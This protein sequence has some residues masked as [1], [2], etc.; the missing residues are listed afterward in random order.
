[1]HN[2][3][4]PCSTESVTGAKHNVM[5]DARQVLLSLPT[6]QRLRSEHEPGESE[7]S[8]TQSK[9]LES[10]EST[11]RVDPNVSPRVP[12]DPKPECDG[13]GPELAPV[14]AWRRFLTEWGSSTV[15]FSK[16][17]RGLT[18]ARLRAMRGLDQ[19]EGIPA[20]FLCAFRGLKKCAERSAGLLPEDLRP[21][22]STLVIWLLTVGPLVAFAAVFVAWLL[23]ATATGRLEM[24]ESNLQAV[25]LDSNIML[26][27][28]ALS[29]Q[30]LMQGVPPLDLEATVHRVNATNKRITKRDSNLTQDL[31]G[32][33]RKAKQAMQT[34]DF[35]KALVLQQQILFND[36]HGSSLQTNQTLRA[37]LLIDQGYALT[38]LGQPKEGANFLSAGLQQIQGRLPSFALNALG[39]AYMQQGNL[40][41][42]WDAFSSAAYADP[43]QDIVW[44]NMGVTALLQ[45]RHVHADMAFEQAV[46]LR[47]DAPSIM[48]N[49]LIL[50]GIVE[51]KKPSTTPVM[52][53]FYQDFQ[54]EIS[55]RNL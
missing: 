47:P 21:L 52:E 45:G 35:E 28:P 36:T 42:A 7:A 44:S 24:P 8:F 11:P 10:Q 39:F 41:H 9:G 12:G 29:Q 19:N 13:A 31:A 53:L 1:M 46:L 37:E 30:M 2:A 43:K 14:L 34:S 38:V 20:A 6:P 27:H 5:L 18:A 26:T 54:S 15:A 51:K 40:A 23:P 49:V 22:L 50:K 32:A 16:P 25:K 3:E 55:R 17:C 48:T 4:M 33:C